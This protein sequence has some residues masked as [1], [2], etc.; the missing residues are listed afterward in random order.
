MCPTIDR[1]IGKEGYPK[2]TDNWGQRDCL[3]FVCSNKHMTASFPRSNKVRTIKTAI[4]FD[5]RPSG[6]CKQKSF[7]S[8]L[9]VGA[10]FLGL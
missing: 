6:G 3:F 2:K 10:N 8:I 1:I 7:R 9:C 5:E 4:G